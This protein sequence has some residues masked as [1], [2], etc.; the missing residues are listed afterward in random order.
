MVEPYL[1]NGNR[2]VT[3]ITLGC[4]QPNEGPE[5]ITFY[6]ISYSVESN[7]VYKSAT[8]LRRTDFVFQ[9]LDKM[10]QSDDSR[11]SRQKKDAE[12]NRKSQIKDQSRWL[13][14]L[15]ALNRTMEHDLKITFTVNHQLL[16]N[17]RNN[18]SARHPS[19]KKE[20]NYL[21]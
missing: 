19:N 20:K 6:G 15:K 21:D 11:L 4:S 1:D 10:P 5:S 2:R 18:I 7:R 17:C 13:F 16:S 12:A 9:L 14:G 8:R 3:L